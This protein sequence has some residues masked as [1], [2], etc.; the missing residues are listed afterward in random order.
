LIRL[1][2]LYMPVVS[3]T[4]K[5]LRFNL[6]PKHGQAKEYQVRDLLAKIGPWEARR[7]AD[8]VR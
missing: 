1:E 7:A 5:A 6:Q 4:A 2:K 8:Q 3:A